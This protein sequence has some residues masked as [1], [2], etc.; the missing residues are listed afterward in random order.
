MYKDDIL[1]L[2]KVPRVLVQ[3][4]SICR[5]QS[6]RCNMNMLMMCKLCKYRTIISN[7][8]NKFE[9]LYHHKFCLFYRQTS[10]FSIAESN[11]NELEKVPHLHSIW[12]IKSSTFELHTEKRMLCYSIQHIRSVQDN[13]ATPVT[14]IDDHSLYQHWCLIICIHQSWFIWYQQLPSV[15]LVHHA[16][17]NSLFPT[18]LYHS[19]TSDWLNHVP[20]VYFN[21]YMLTSYHSNDDWTMT[22]L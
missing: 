2:T 7:F 4:S 5:S 22:M 21:L 20:C 12:Y 1:L 15:L 19:V 9:F 10:N 11:S 3:Y 8:L 6:I 13:V 14:A 17:S 16:C 18:Y